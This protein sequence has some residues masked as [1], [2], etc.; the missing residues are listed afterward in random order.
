MIRPFALL[1]FTLLT[2]VWAQGGDEPLFVNLDNVKGDPRGGVDIADEKLYEVIR[3]NLSDQEVADAKA[4]KGAQYQ[5]VYDAMRD[6]SWDNAII[7]LKKYI[8]IVRTAYAPGDY[9]YREV[10]S[11]V[12]Y[13]FGKV[14]LAQKNYLDAVR[15]FQ[16][17]LF[18]FKDSKYAVKSSV[19]WATIFFKIYTGEIKTHQAL[20]NPSANLVIKRL[21][22]LKT[23]KPDAEELADCYLL[24]ADVC[25]REKNSDE[26]KRY[27][28]L[29]QNEFPKSEAAEKVA[30][31]KAKLN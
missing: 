8:D 7:E 1:A 12:F 24:A 5:V 15:N 23:I 26:A 30:E 19:E 27:L 21:L 25:I 31:R 14:Y 4:Q 2:L 29:I 28:K 20:G 10:L 16:R 11:E 6:E 18:Q 17:V 3:D 9:G 13:M 22:H